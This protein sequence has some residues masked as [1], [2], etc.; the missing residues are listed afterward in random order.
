MGMP[1]GLAF[2]RKP[3][4]PYTRH[5]QLLSSILSAL[6][7]GWA[8]N[9]KR[10][11]PDLHNLKDELTLILDSISALNNIFVITP[12]SCEAVLDDSNPGHLGVE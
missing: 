8:A 4:E 5:L 6:N 11:L 2:T 7:R 12:T 3:M 10:K 9:V 1:F